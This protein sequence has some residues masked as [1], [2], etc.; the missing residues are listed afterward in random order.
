M[1]LAFSIIL[2]FPYMQILRQSITRELNLKISTV[3]HYYSYLL[4]AT[5]P[6]T[7]LFSSESPFKLHYKG[8]TSWQLLMNVL[9]NIKVKYERKDL[10]SM[11]CHGTMDDEYSL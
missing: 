11:N 6:P 2:G 10:G 9:M 7:A 5:L 4:D 3:P 8:R 1:A